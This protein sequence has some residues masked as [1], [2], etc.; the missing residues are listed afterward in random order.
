M[1]EKQLAKIES[2]LASVCETQN[3][4]CEKLEVLEQ[5]VARSNGEATCEETVAFLDQFR[6]NEAAA[7]NW[8]GAWIENSDIAC[9]RG[10]L[11]TV[12]QRETIHAELLENRIKE[13][14]GSCTYKIP[15]ADRKRYLETYGGTACSDAEKVKALVGEVGDVDAF[16][17]P[18]DDFSSRLDGDPETQF[19][20]RTIVQD[21][22]STIQFLNDACALLNG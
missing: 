19:L 8:I 21:E 1:S 7:A 20:L 9:L 18:F 11:R 16:L 5:R 17:K 15:E 3:A 10:G 13:L 14:G 4:L 22:R 2:L 6:A 12:Q